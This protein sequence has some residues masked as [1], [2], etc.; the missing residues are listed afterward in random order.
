MRG[1]WLPLLALPVLAQDDLPIE[2]VPLADVDTLSGWTLTEDGILD[3][4]TYRWMA[5]LDTLAWA[6]NPSTTITIEGPTGKR[7]NLDF[8]GDTLRTSG[9]LP[10]DEAGRRFA[11]AAHFYVREMKCGKSGRDG[12]PM[13]DLSDSSA[14]YLWVTVRVDSLN[15]GFGHTVVSGNGRLYTCTDSNQGHPALVNNCHDWAYSETRNVCA[16]SGICLKRE[17]I[18]RI[19]KRHEWQRRELIPPDPSEFDLLRM[20]LRR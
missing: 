16:G 3:T 6:W 14:G 15:L 9:D 10:L 5:N 18:C 7:L 8:S 2:S 20:E 13:R 19:C 4:V 1:L 17:R 11:E 12:K